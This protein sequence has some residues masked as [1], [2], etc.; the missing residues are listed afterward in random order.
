MRVPLIL[1]I[2]G[3][4]GGRRLE[5][6]AQHEDLMPTILALVDLEAPTGI[7]GFDLLPWIRG[8]A[9]QSPRA[10]VFGRRKSI[11]GH[12][13]Q[14]YARNAERKWIGRLDGPGQIFRPDR[15]PREL[16]AGPGDGPPASL[17]AVVGDETGPGRTRR[18]DAETRR[19]LEALGY[20]E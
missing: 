14:Y 5:G 3:M 8:E 17:E 18:V 7:D 11:P 6:L 9:Q 20:A 4:P 16:S 12:P 19:A 1:R 2:P 13:D 15:D 10:E